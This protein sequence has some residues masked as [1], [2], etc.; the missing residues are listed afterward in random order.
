MGLA[1]GAL[2]GNLTHSRVG[3]LQ[4]WLASLGSTG[5][6]AVPPCTLA[7]LKSLILF[8]PRELFIPGSAERKQLCGTSP[9]TWMPEASLASGSFSNSLSLGSK[10]M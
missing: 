10:C 9:G 4:P 6:G 8:Q 5:A 1:A 7:F 2:E 3:G